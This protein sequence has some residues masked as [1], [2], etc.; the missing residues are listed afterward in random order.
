[1]ELKEYIK[2]IQTDKNVIIKTAILTL[3]FSVFFSYLQKTSYESSVSLFIAKD[4]TQSTDEFKYDGYYA[5]QSG[6]IIADSVEKMLQSPQIVSEIYQDANID[7]DFDKIKRYKKSFIAHKMSNQYVEVSFNSETRENADR[8]SESI[9]KVVKQKMEQTKNSSEDEISFSIER[10]T[11]VIIEKKPDV[12]LNS[13]IGL[14]SGIF[15]GTIIVLVKK[16]F[17]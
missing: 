10:N 9:T 14:I 11:P 6:E 3:A 1:M 5:L 15:L 4:G 13:L 16:Y 2:I 17:A 8:I 7:S 12:A